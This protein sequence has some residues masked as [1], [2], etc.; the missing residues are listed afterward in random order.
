M[1]ALP[2]SLALLP[3]LSGYSYPGRGVVFGDTY[4][5]DNRDHR[6]HKETTVERYGSR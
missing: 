3:S 4:S 1:N 2:I 6:I 5:N